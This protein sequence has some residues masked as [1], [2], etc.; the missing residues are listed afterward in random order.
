MARTQDTVSKYYAADI[1]Q[2][3]SALHQGTHNSK[4]RAKVIG[5]CCHNA[6]LH[7]SELMVSAL[8]EGTTQSYKACAS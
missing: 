5:A 6:R 7:I 8:L 4:Q 2:Y 1:P 3:T